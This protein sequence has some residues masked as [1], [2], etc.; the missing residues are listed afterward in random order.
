MVNSVLKNKIFNF[1]KEHEYGISCSD[2]S[3]KLKVNRITLSKYLSVLES[4]GFVYYRGFGMAKAWYVQKSPII[5]YFKGENGHAVKHVLDSIG[6]GI[7][8]L[9]NNMDILWANKIMK[10]MITYKKDLRGVNFAEIFQNS[11][12]LKEEL[13]TNQIRK[14]IL[15]DAINSQEIKTTISPILNINNDSVGFIHVL[16]IEK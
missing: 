15:K 13:K 12:N 3:K 9:D 8:V 10:E 7:L 5:E 16:N 6:E 11:E 2:I 1:I 14:A 4:E